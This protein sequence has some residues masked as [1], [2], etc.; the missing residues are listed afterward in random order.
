MHPK[1]LLIYS[2]PP[3]PTRHPTSNEAQG[4][5]EIGLYTAGQTTANLPLPGEIC[6]LP[7]SLAKHFLTRIGPTNASLIRIVIAEYSAAAEELFQIK[8][9]LTPRPIRSPLA[10]AMLAR[11]QARA[12]TPLPHPHL[13]VPTLRERL[14]AFGIAAAQLRVLGVSLAPYGDDYATNDLMWREDTRLV[15]HRAMRETW[16]ARK[17]EEGR[18]ERVVEGICGRERELVRAEFRVDVD[19]KVG[20][21]WRVQWMGRKWMVFRRAPE[22]DAYGNVALCVRT[23]IALFGA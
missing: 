16:L 11:G 20:F 19:A 7:I 3:L 2:G 23:R 17:N 13:S 1:L 8:A 14:A 10:R 12:A 21:G 9:F 22:V 5:G 18:M 15:G 6:T 4:A